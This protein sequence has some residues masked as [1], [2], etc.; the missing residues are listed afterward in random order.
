[1]D[2]LLIAEKHFASI[3]IKQ[4]QNEMNE[5]IEKKLKEALKTPIAK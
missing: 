4:M 5:Y 1:M 2:P 3:E